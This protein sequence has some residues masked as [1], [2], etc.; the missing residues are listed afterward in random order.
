MVATTT[1][2]PCPANFMVSYET[3]SL[4]I[5]RIR[6]KCNLVE[7]TF[8]EPVIKG[9]FGNNS[10]ALADA[11][12]E[13]QKRSLM[14]AAREHVGGE[15]I[16]AEYVME[17]LRDVG[18]ERATWWRNVVNEGGY[19]R[20]SAVAAFGCGRVGRSGDGRGGCFETGVPASLSDRR[21][22]ERSNDVGCLGRG[23]TM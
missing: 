22:D 16:L 13:K 7:T 19:S 15:L 20:Y 8:E 3:R 10:P 1:D 21:H 5:L 14:S 11:F 23:E 9:P 18:S 6:L 4:E 17:S 2:H 12:G